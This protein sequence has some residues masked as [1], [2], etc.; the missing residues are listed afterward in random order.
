MLKVSSK[1]KYFI[2]FFQLK[3]SNCNISKYKISWLPYFGI[4]KYY[5]S[6]RPEVFCKNG[7]LRNFAKSTG[8]H[9]CQSLILNKVTNLRQKVSFWGA[10]THANIIEIENFLLQ[11]KDHKSGSK[12]GWLFHYFSFKGIM[13]FWSQRVHSFCWTKI[14]TLIKTKRNQKWAIRFIQPPVP[15]PIIQLPVPGPILI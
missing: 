8:K 13:T 4:K 3:I 1:L 12:S 5:R 6:S 7:V 2:I 9:L 10:P 15:G 11:L 14:W